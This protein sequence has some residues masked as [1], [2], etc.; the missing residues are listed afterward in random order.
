VQEG[1]D[2][3]ALNLTRLS[4]SISGHSN[5]VKKLVVFKSPFILATPLFYTTDSLFNFSVLFKYYF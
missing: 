5:Q 1:R 3:G 2:V 4:Q